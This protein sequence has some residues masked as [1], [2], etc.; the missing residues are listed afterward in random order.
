MLTP[1]D[2]HVSPPLQ[3][4][5]E[6]ARAMAK[7]MGLTVLTKEGADA[8]V[9][10]TSEQLPTKSIVLSNPQMLTPGENPVS[11][12]LQHTGESARARAKSM[13]PTVLTKTG[14]DAEVSPRKQHTSEQ[15]S[16]QSRVLSN[17]RVPT[18]ED[19]QVTPPLQ[20]TE[21][22]ARAE[23]KK[24]TVARAPTKPREDRDSS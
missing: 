18:P 15:L 11:L 23:A 13:G 14:V 3:H 5:G 10:H 16:T 22:S 4:T 17:P 20:N 12:P 19:T 6:S 1:G 7:S 9:S 24:K 21:E 8:E 2:N